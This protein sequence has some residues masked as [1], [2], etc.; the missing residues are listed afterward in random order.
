MKAPWKGGLPLRPPPFRGS[1][2]VELP[3]FRVYIR[4]TSRAANGFTHT[5]DLAN[6][7]A[8]NPGTGA[9]SRAIGPL[10]EAARSVGRAVYVENVLTG[11]FG[12][13]WERRGY[14]VTRENPMSYVLKCPTC[15]KAATIKPNN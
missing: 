2:W 6:I 13:W 1:A 11:R 9:L 10:E 7:E 8:D 3:G 5:L 15:G 14:A 4:L 12:A